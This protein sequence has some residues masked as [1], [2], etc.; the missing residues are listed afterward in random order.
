MTPLVKPAFVQLRI[1]Q[2][3]QWG[4]VK[5]RGEQVGS[6]TSLDETLMSAISEAHGGEAS[7]L[8]DALFQP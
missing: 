7:A 6:Q 2:H 4:A 8:A 3:A 5:Q 1:E